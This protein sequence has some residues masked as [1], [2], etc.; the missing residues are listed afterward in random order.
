MTLARLA[1]VALVFTAAGCKQGIGDRCQ[2]T[3]DCGTD[4]TGMQL[5]CQ[6]KTM[7]ST[8]SIAEGGTCQPA[9]AL[10]PD[11]SGEQGDMA[12]MPPDMLGDL[13]G[14]MPDM[15]MDMTMTLPADM[16]TPPDMTELPDLTDGATD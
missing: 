14:V 7:N 1:F 3:D 6:L 4:D 5:V 13:V 12:T 11:M 15:A 2:V 9:G 10:L 16:A 8:N